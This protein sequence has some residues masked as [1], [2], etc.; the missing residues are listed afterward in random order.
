[1]LASSFQSN[2]VLKIVSDARD[3]DDHDADEEEKE[4]EDVDDSQQRQ[5]EEQISNGCM[6]RY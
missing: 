2:I 1:M 5:R 4:E 6:S 3:H